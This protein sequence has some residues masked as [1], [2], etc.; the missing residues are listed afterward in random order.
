VHYSSLISTGRNISIVPVYGLSICNNTLRGDWLSDE[1]QKHAG[2]LINT[3][4]VF[5]RWS[6]NDP[7][8]AI[9]AAGNASMKFV[10]Q[11]WIIQGNNSSGY[12]VWDQSGSP[13]YYGFDTYFL[14]LAFNTANK[15][16]DKA[17]L[18]TGNVAYGSGLSFANPRGPISALWPEIGDSSA[19]FNFVYAAATKTIN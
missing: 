6:T 16:L 13:T 15:D 9:P 12:S 3:S 4:P 5:G 18:A 8:P 14:S 11:G 2:F 1:S 10:C 7:N 19:T 17:G